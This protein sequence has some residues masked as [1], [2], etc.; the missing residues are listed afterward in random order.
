M[1]ARSRC[2]AALA[3]LGLLAGCAGTPRLESVIMMP[4]TPEPAADTT[5]SAAA[6]KRAPADSAGALDQVVLLLPFANSSDYEGSWDIYNGVAR[7]LADTLASN[8]FLRVVALD[9]AQAYLHPEERH[10]QIGLP[11]AVELGKLLGADWVILGEIEDLTMRRFQATVPLGGYRNYE[12]VVTV[13]LVLVNA[14][15][16][17]RRGEVRAEGV[18]DSKQTGITNPA[19][20]VPFDKQYYF[21]HDLEWGSEA[22][23]E[24]L[25]GKALAQWARKAADGIG[26]NIR[27]PPSLAVS[28]PKVIDIDGEVAYINVGLAEGIRN[29]DKFGIWD[30]GRELTDPQTGTV[31]GRALPRRVGVVQVEQVLS[32]HLSQGRVLEGA[33]EIHKFYS[34]RAE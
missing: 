16:G 23:G 1:S 4:P 30:D 5:A 29:G 22:F 27:P 11:R 25:V 31:L 7:A 26:Q 6:R 32:D 33:G 15:D 10:G 12:G 20:F 3:G 18:A 14:V 8:Q 13:N 19:A 17:R 34:V 24:S 21:L 2:A 28:E 9:S